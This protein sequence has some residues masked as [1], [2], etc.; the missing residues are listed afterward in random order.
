MAWSYDPTDLDTETSPGQLN[1]VRLLIGDNQTGDPQMQD[2]EITFALSQNNNSVYQSA[3]YCCRLLAS[4]YARMVNTQL[5]GALQAEY[6]DRA[7]QYIT[8]AVQL[9]EMAKK[10]SGSGGGLGVSGGGVSISD[11]KVV[12]ENTDRV[13][14]AFR[15][16]QFEGGRASYIPEF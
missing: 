8:L 13:K 16:G 10:A 15:V 2:E 7:K 9:S 1:V 4:K 6:S 3:V 12:E 11:M 14:P 5:D